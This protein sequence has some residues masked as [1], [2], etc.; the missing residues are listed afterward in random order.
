MAWSLVKLCTR[1]FDQAGIWLFMTIVV[2]LF[3][4][5]CKFTRHLV[6]LIGN[7]RLQNLQTLEVPTMLLVFRDHVVSLGNIH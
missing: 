5:Y 4:S 7:K 2:I 6:Y 3:L 1:F